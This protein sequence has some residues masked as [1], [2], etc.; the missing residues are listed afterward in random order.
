MTQKQKKTNSGDP[1]RRRM[2]KLL[3]TPEGRAQLAVKRGLGGVEF[4]HAAI[5][6]R[7]ASKLLREMVAEITKRQIHSMPA[8]TEVKTEHI[9]AA[10]KLEK[11]WI[12]K[13]RERRVQ[14]T[15]NAD[16]KLHIAVELAQIFA[17]ADSAS[18]KPFFSPPVDGS[19]MY[20]GA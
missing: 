11:D 7:S 4:V 18:S 3:S 19:L 20:P 16:A 5:V 1:R 10:K 2:I 14:L 8:I 12:E 6:G 9:E 17:S 13:S 15:V